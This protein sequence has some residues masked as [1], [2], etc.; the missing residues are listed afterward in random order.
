MAEFIYNNVK[1]I[2]TS[3]IPFELNCEYHFCVSYE[4][5]FDLRSKSRTTEEFSFEFLDLMT[6]YQ[7]NLYFAQ[8][9]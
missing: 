2:S 6:V 4:Q 3:H 7:Q 1:N 5:D 9:F 8:E